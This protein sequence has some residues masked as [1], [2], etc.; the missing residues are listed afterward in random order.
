MVQALEYSLNF[1]EFIEWY[2]DDGK[3]YELIDGVIVEVKPTGAHEKIAGF[4]ARK[5][6]AAIDRQH[7]NYFIPRTCSIKPSSTKSG[8]LPDVAVL[9]EETIDENPR[10][11]KESTITAGKTAK[12]I[13]EVTSTNWRDDYERKIPDY[14]EMGVGEYWILDYLGLA[15]ARHIGNPKQPVLTICELINGEYQ[16]QQLRGN[17]EIVSPTLGD[18]EMTAEQLFNAG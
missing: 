4:L 17:T 9:D 16:L 14:E 15:A 3:L 18:L 1:E 8:F 11:K 5:F 13:V 6:W 10:W 7:L 2:P 12:L